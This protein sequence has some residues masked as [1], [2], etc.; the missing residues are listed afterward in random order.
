MALLFLYSQ[1][2]KTSKN[3]LIESL[4]SKSAT[5]GKIF[6]K[7]SVKKEGDKVVWTMF[8]SH[9]GVKAKE[10]DW[11][12][13]EIIIDKS[14][15]PHLASFHQYK[16]G[17]EVEYR[18]SCYSCHASGTRA[19]RPKFDSLEAPLS[20]LQK[21]QIF[22]WNTQMK[23]DSLVVVASSTLNQAKRK[24]AFYPYEQK[25]P[26]ALKVK[27]CLYCHND[28]HRNSLNQSHSG[29]IHFLVNHNF[30]PPFPFTLSKEE[31][32]ELNQ[33]LF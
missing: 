15:K 22:I 7:I 24:I 18:I 8:Q 21:A 6:N 14:V 19:I 10:S 2:E 32:R 25:M 11:D 28:M 23:L 27:T 9:Y 29:T 33:F 20:L 13:L 17:K 4:E 5:G 1:Q 30:M 12:E 31:R 26:K 16:M 3:I